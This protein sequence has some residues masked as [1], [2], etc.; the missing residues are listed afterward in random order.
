MGMMVWGTF[1]EM[2]QER[3]REK[4]RTELSGVKDREMSMYYGMGFTY[5]TKYQKERE[6]VGLAPN[7]ATLM[8]IRPHHS[9]AEINGKG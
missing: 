3:P 7:W 8:I 6:K 9:N 2:Q 1:C 5:G 4:S